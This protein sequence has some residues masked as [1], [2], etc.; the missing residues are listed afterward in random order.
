MLF[1]PTAT[2]ALLLALPGLAQPPTPNEFDSLQKTP[3]NYFELSAPYV[4]STLTNRNWNFGGDSFVEIN[5]YIRLTRDVQ[6]QDGWLW[7]KSPTM[8]QSWA[9]EFEFRVKYFGGLSGDGFA[10]WYTKNKEREGPVFGNQ[11]K[12][13]GLGLFF[14]TYANSRVRHSYPYV[15]GMIGNGLT[16]YDHDFDGSSNEAG[17]CAAEFRN[18]EVN[19]KARVT[20]L[21][22][23]YL[24]VELDTD[25]TGTYTNC[26][27]ANVTLP[28]GYYWG[29]SALTGGVSSQHDIIS[30]KAW[31]ILSNE[32][33]DIYKSG[34]VNDNKA[35]YYQDSK[36][37]S[38]D[39]PP[40]SEG[41]G[42]VTILVILI[43]VAIVG[44]VGWVAYRTS[45]AN[46]YKRF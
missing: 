26:F 6:S 9:V 41:W 33:S 31:H 14:D 25:N 30:V 17:G 32:N 40:K 4:D 34:I 43:L 37:G 12:F 21:N 45:Q 35:G 2:A 10:F 44:Y 46:N 3:L 1:N 11:D 27:Q 24:K 7:T 42:V 38:T 39:Y 13:E 5:K 23:K 15:M 22:Q 19:S 36:H 28:V 20:Y 29:F 18:L 8:P 16:K